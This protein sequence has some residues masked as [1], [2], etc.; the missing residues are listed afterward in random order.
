[1]A[2]RVLLR[3]F[4]FFSHR[5][6]VGCVAPVLPVPG[7]FLDIAAPLQIAKG[8]FDGGAGQLQI[9]G[10]GLDPRP[11]L[12]TGAGAVAEVHIDR[13]RPVGQ[14]LVGV[15]APEPAHGV[16]PFFP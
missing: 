10:D 8:S 3:R 6:E 16:I 14:L 9:G 12:A 11:A 5:V 4:F 2:F 13:P 1:M 15:D 7:R